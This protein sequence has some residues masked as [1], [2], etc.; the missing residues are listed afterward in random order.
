MLANGWVTTGLEP[1]EEA[2]D[3]ARETYDVDAR[4]SAELFNLPRPV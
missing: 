4:P 2:G 3:R 1:D